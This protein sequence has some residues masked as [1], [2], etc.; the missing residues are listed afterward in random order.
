MSKTQN[1]MSACNGPS[2]LEQGWDVLSTW[3]SHIKAEKQ[4]KTFAFHL[5]ARG[6]HQ[7]KHQ[8]FLKS[9]GNTGIT[10]TWKAL[11]V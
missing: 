1:I 6:E 7:L 11:L 10:P 9:R 8:V 4:E 3:F 5:Q 2:A